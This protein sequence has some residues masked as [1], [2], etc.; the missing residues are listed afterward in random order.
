MNTKKQMY[1]APSITEHVIELEQGIAAGSFGNGTL[2]ST[3]GV[4]DWTP[5]SDGTSNGDL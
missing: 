3:P 2:P 1:Q 4:D 5:G